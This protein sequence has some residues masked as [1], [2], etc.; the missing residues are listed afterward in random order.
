LNQP[1]NSSSH[2]VPNYSAPPEGSRTTQLPAGRVGP[3]TPVSWP[4]RTAR[5][6]QVPQADVADGA[7]T[8]ST[9][10]APTTGTDTNGWRASTR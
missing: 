10:V 8:H 1:S 4:A 9:Q 2:A 3:Y 5:L 7:Q 6:P